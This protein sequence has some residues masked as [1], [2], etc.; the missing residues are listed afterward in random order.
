MYTADQITSKLQTLVDLRTTVDAARAAAK[1]KLATEATQSPPLRAFM[2]ALRSFVKVNFSTSPDV[3]ADFGIHPK[4]ARTAL[5]SRKWQRLSRSLGT[6]NASGAAHDGLAAERG[7]QGRRHRRRRDPDR[8]PVSHRDATEWPDGPRD[9][10]RHDGCEQP[11]G[12]G[13][14]THRVSGECA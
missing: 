1:A 9:E 13:D 3:L 14:A 8:C 5:R 2:S 12:C 11:D 6:G 10:R 7:N 4:R